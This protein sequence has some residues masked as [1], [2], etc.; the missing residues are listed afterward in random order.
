MP[1]SFYIYTEM[2]LLKTKISLVMEKKNQLAQL[3][4]V[5]INGNK[6]TKIIGGVKWSAKPP[7]GFTAGK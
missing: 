7:T 4:A 5:M 1:N 2:I 3:K 6:Q